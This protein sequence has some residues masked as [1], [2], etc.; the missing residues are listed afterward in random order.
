MTILSLILALLLEQLRPIS[1]R[2]RFYLAFT[3]MANSLERALNAGEYRNGVY[4]WLIATVP[5]LVISVAGYW[6]LVGLSPFLGLAWNVVILYLTMGFRQ[7]SHSFSGISKALQVGDLE[8]A[9]ALLADWTGQH[10][11]Q[12][13]ED[14]VARFAI[15]QGLL[16]SYRYV[17]GTVFW[18][19]V[20]AWLAGPVGA[21]L[22]RAAS[23]LAQ[24][25]SSHEQVSPFGRCAAGVLAILDYLPVRF[26]AAGFAVMGDFEDAVYCWRSQ[27]QA[28]GNYAQGIILA[29]GAGAIGIR[30]GQALHMDHT[31][32]FRPELGLGDAANANYLA[33]AVGL[34]WRSILL[35]LAVVLLF[36][37]GKWLA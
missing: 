9:R 6:L 8:T 32:K 5:L 3:R 11:S 10:T 7:F 15:E 12:M 17:F 33:S 30:L 28:W 4:G 14:E 31:V 29:A 20:L 36:S 13:S 1:S 16:D 21:V 37:L 2:N 22:Y 35:W 24:K 19:V 25:W 34:I 23:L 27:A 18:F 26:T